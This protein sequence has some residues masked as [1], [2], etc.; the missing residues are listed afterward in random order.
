VLKLARMI[1]SLNPLSYHSNPW[2][3][4]VRSKGEKSGEP[5]ML[6]GCFGQVFVAMK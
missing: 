2:R 6:G 1:F 5:R 3:I 4:E